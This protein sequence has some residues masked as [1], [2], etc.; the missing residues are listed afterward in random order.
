MRVTEVNE[1]LNLARTVAVRAGQRLAE[2]VDAGDRTYTHSST[3]P[4]EVKASADIALEEEILRALVP[5]GISI[6]TEEAGC[7]PGVRSSTLRFIV[8]PLDG[9]FNFVKGLGPSAVSI[10]LWDDNQPLF[11]VIYSLRD[12]RLFVGGPGIGADC[13]GHAIS[14]SETARRDRASICTGFPARLNVDTDEGARRLWLLA[15]TYGKV[16]MIGSAAVSLTHVASGAADAYA[17]QNVMLWDVAAGIALV[18]GAGGRTR[19]RPG[20][21]EYACDVLASNQLL[22]E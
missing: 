9:T 6:L 4:K 14:V 7:L 15:R 21:V 20:T 10:A 19:L 16:R 8:D 13:D 2:S 17:E 22:F 18:E 12:R 3:V 1:F 5:T 11:G